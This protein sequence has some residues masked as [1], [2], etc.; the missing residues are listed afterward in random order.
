[1]VLSGQSAPLNLY[2]IS[3]LAHIILQ[4]LQIGFTEIRFCGR[5]CR[6]LGGTRLVGLTSPTYR[7][8]A[9]MMYGFDKTGCQNMGPLVRSCAD[10]S[11]FLHLESGWFSGRRATAP[12]SSPRKARDKASQEGCSGFFKPLAALCRLSSPKRLQGPLRSICHPQSRQ[13]LLFAVRRTHFGISRRR[14]LPHWVGERVF[15]GAKKG[16]AFRCTGFAR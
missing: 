15:G 4:I 7:P 14:R 9:L 11:S 12:S 3:H 1:M 10:V 16:R 2:P 8:S 13:P 5:P 6:T